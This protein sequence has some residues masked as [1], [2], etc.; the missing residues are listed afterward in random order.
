MGTKNMC[1]RVEYY[2]L[3]RYKVEKY[4]NVVTDKLSNVIDKI[5]IINYLLINEL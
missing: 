1:K 4:R 3:Y 2:F 5:I